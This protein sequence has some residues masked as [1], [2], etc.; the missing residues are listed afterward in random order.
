MI[1]CMEKKNLRRLREKYADELSGKIIVMLN[2]PDEYEYMDDDL[3]DI[4]KS[5]VEEYL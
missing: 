2:I 4:L 5:C 3:V 1:F